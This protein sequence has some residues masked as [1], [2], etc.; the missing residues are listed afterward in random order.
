MSPSPI[1]YDVAVLGAGFGGLATALGLAEAGCRVVLLETLG[2]AG[3]CAA[4]FERRGDRF[5]AGATLFSGFAEGQLMRRWIERHRLEVRHHILDPVVELRLPSFRLAVPPDRRRWVERLGAL[6]GAPVHGLQAFFE[7]QGRVA[8]V[9]WPLFDEPGLL[10]PLGPGALAAHLRRIP[11]YLPLLRWVGKPLVAVLEHFGVA[12]FEPLRSYV[13]ATCQITV[14]APAAEAEALFALAALDYHFR[15]TGHVEGGI[16]ALASE[17]VGAIRGHGGEVR[18]FERAER[19]EAVPGGWRV[20]TRRG[21][22][23][24]RRVVAN[25]LPRAVLSLLD[26]AVPAGSRARRRLE[27]RSQ[28]VATGW[29][30]AMLY[31]VLP[32]GGLEHTAAYHLELV[33]DASK[34]LIEGNHLFCSVSAAA[35]LGRTPQDGRTVTVSTHVPMD[36]LRELDGPGRAAY[37]GRVQE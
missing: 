36:R 16:G 19:L 15:G 2:Y 4:T 34:P 26:G 24:A 6:P 8:D 28:R 10:P 12:G 11:S 31:L 37:V 22:L 27:A 18:F 7:L 17:L 35:E 29:G 20:W 14:Q 21:S 5:E 33:Q 13:D 25:L 23:E 32:P 3:G 1:R 9:L 30:A